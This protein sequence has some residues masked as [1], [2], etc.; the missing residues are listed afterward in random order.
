[1]D[2]PSYLSDDVIKLPSIPPPKRVTLIDR[3][4]NAGYFDALPLELC[5]SVLDLLD[6]QTVAT[7]SCLNYKLYSIVSALKSFEE[8]TAHAWRVLKILTVI[9]TIS[10]FSVARLQAVLRSDRCHLCFA[11]GRSLHIP[12]CERCCFNCPSYDRSFTMLY[13]AIAEKYYGL[14]CEEAKRI[15]LCA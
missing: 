4:S 10:H 12:T 15:P 6:P 11:Y 5:H 2:C 7:V 8:T 3:A 13:P 14:T 1:M 9:G